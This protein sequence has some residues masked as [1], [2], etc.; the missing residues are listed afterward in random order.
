M[1]RRVPWWHPW[2][3]ALLLLLL[4]QA[5][6]GSAHLPPEPNPIRCSGC[7]YFLDTPTHL[8]TAVGAAANL[9]CGVR[10]LGDRQ[11]SWIRRRDLHVLTTA[12]YTYTTDSRFRAIHAR[13]SPYWV[14]RIDSPTVN[15]SGVY[16]CQVSAQPKISRRFHLSVVVPRATIAGTSAVFMKAGSDINITCIITGASK[17]TPV[18]WYHITPQSRSTI[19]EEL[20]SGTRGGVQLVTDRRAGTSWLL[21]TQAT[22][23]D[24]GNY[25]C[26]P[27]HAT[28]ASVS[29][30]ILDEKTP[31]AMQPD[32][33][34]SPGAPAS[35]S[36]SSSLL[37]LFFLLLL[38]F[39]SLFL[40]LRSSSWLPRTLLPLAQPRLRSQ[41][42]L[43]NHK[44]PL[45]LV[46]EL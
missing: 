16:E 38:L 32:L 27:A 20:N 35:P 34:A 1:E 10:M 42:I 40:H 31:A 17:A 45:L 6:Q 36:S 28:P 19:M 39:R 12:S 33:Q 2:C 29:V 46:L 21:V 25:T 37:L 9:T 44:L 30:H 24:A 3:W 23:R 5:R 41:I 43:Q 11:V 15:D 26:A 14:L 22:W 7:P 13:K 8:I 18:T 4:Q